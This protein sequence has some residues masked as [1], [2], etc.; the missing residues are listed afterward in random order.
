MFDVVCLSSKRV[1]RI[2]YRIPPQYIKK[3]NKMN[4]TRE[5][6]KYA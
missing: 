6:M 4:A 3:I 5:K 1:N 2:H